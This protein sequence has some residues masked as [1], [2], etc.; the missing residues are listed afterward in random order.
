MTDATPPRRLRFT[1]R[2][3]F[4]AMAFIGAGLAWRVYC[5]NWIEQ[6][7]ELRSRKSVHGHIRSRSAQDGETPVAPVDAPWQLR[8]FGEPG[9]AVILVTSPPDGPL[10]A[11]E[12]SDI[13][14][15]RS[16]FP[17]ATII[18]IADAP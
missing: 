1:L 2:A 4:L 11:E 12:S 7:H 13:A 9:I 16:V 8:L 15:L 6:R 17:E 18:G 10:T 14:W 5:T 3:I